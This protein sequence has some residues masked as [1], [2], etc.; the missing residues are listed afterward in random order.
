MGLPKG[1]PSGEAERAVRW[2]YGQLSK[3]TTAGWGLPL[4]GGLCQ[5]VWGG[6]WL[7]ISVTA[8]RS[9]STSE[10]RARRS[11]G[12]GALPRRDPYD[13]ESPAPIAE[14]ALH[15]RFAETATSISPTGRRTKRPGSR[16]PARAST[17]ARS[18]I[19]RS[20][21]SRPAL[22]SRPRPER[23][24]SSLPTARSSCPSGERGT[25]TS[26]EDSALGPTVED[27]GEAAAH[28]RHDPGARA[29]R[30]EGA[31]A[32]SAD[33]RTRSRCRR[34]GSP[35]V[36]GLPAPGCNSS[37]NLREVRAGSP[38]SAALSSRCC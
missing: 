31:L 22:R 18:A 2:E 35:G 15:P 9:R 16:W 17:A 5:R 19:W 11:P 34:A 20:C 10:A 23:V 25:G 24:S 7:K 13:S 29:H 4:S 27:G 3:E 26:T 33:R 12:R 37:S 8:G 28:A 21:T 30:G 1:E 14:V 38:R 36:P 32:R 6:T